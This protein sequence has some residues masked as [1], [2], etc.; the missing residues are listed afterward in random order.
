MIPTEATHVTLRALQP[1]RC[2]AKNIQQDENTLT[3]GA[4]DRTPKHSWQP[5]S[6]ISSRRKWRITVVSAAAVRIAKS[7]AP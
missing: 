4:S 2:R 7:N 3:Q 1:K 5:Y 6:A